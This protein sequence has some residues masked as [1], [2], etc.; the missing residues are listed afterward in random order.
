MQKYSEPSHTFWLHLGAVAWF[1][2]V[3]VSWLHWSWLSCR[4]AEEAEHCR[5]GKIAIVVPPR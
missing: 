1:L 2:E 4:D 5:F 3:T